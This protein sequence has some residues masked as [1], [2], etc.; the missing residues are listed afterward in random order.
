MRQMVRAMSPRIEFAVVVLIAFGY[1]MLGS[2]L[3]LL[4]PE[5]VAAGMDER[6]LRFLVGYELIALWLLTVFLFARGWRLEQL[7]LRVAASDLPLGLAL[8]LGAYIVFLPIWVVANLFM[9]GLAGQSD[10]LVEV[11]LTPATVVLVSLLNPVFEEVFVCAYVISAVRERRGIVFAVN[12]SVALRLSYHLYQGAVGVVG[13]VP[14]GLVFGYWYART[15]RLWPVIVAH[16]V[17][18]FVALWPY[19]VW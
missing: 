10:A 17:F 2:V 4:G 15:G 3:S 8:A 6:D 19:V 1:F 18:D 7:G 13:I 5:G 12:L 16:A 11:G 9:P 14:L